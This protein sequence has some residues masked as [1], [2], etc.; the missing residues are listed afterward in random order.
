MPPR[1]LA[2]VLVACLAWAGNFLAAAWAVRHF[3][4]MAFTALRLALVLVLLAPFLRQPPPGQWPRLAAI[5]LFSGALHFGLVFWGLRLAGDISS[6]AIALQSYIPMS[7]GLALLF[8]GE[9]IRWLTGVGIATAFVGVIVLGFDPTVLDAPEALAFTLAAALALA[10]GTTL[11]RD[12]QGVGTFTVQAWSALLGIGPLVLGSALTEDGQ[13]AAIASAGAR[14]W[15]GV[16]YSALFASILG[17]G[18]LYVLVQRHP[19]SR[20]TPYMLLTPLFAVTLGVLVWGDR[21]GPR[22]L[23]GGGM[24]LLGVL[25][26]TL[27]P[28]TVGT[29]PNRSTRAMGGV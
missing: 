9:R 19:V 18:L 7:A 4:P 24:V 1:D 27:R 20:V 15:G 21:P 8:L 10:I 14:D 28:S 6:V 16:V 3:P 12:L 23:V 17:H 11:M 26:V 25:L 5:C 29:D 13:L 22:L 2:L